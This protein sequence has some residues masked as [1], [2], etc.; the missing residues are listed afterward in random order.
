MHETNKSDVPDSQ[1]L[2]IPNSTLSALKRRFSRQP[3]PAKIRRDVP[4][5]NFCSYSCAI[6]YTTATNREAH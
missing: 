3:E 2:V 4:P 5:G 6:P 1:K